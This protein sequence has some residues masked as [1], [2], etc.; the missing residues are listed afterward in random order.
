MR[1]HRRDHGFAPAIR[2][3]LHAAEA[4]RSGAS[5]SGRGVHVAARIASLA[6]PDEILV[7]E[8]VL[9]AA[10]QPAAHGALRQ[11]RLKGIRSEVTVAP[12]A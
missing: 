2:I 10:R 7:S 4:T 6:G 5:Y 3:G 1:E 12:L 8:G 11:E 9:T